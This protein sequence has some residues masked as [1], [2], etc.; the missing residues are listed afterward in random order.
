MVPSLVTRFATALLA[1]LVVASPSLAR[2]AHDSAH[3]ADRRQT[4]HGVAGHGH[5]H[6]GGHT[7]AGARQPASSR[8]HADNGHL[9]SRRAPELTSR[10]DVGLP[11]APVRHLV[12]ATT[13]PTRL[14]APIRVVHRVERTH[15]PPDL[16]RA[17]PP[18]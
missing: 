15:H 3:A 5:D 1:L 14:S 6:G 2:A 16:P 10:A 18:S 11:A 13:T 7:H 9:S 8:D 4:E 12:V 17:P